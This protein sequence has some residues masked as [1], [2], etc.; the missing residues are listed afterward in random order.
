MLIPYK[1]ICNRYNIKPTGVLHIGAHWAEEAQDYY[2]NGVQRTVWV[3]ADPGCISH[4][5]NVLEPYPNHIIFNDCIS[6][7]DNQEV[8]LNISNNQGQSSSLLELAH[9]KIA[10][11]EVHYIDTIKLRTKRVDTLFKQ[12]KLNISDYQFVNID[13][14]GNELKA[15]KGMGELLSQVS[16]LY[17]EINELYLYTDCALVSEIDEYVAQFGFKGVETA[18][19]GNTGWGDKLYIK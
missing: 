15:L 2:N 7:R 13:I 9:H 1:D 12:N 4:A 6:D 14:Q 5:I 17:L 18:M 16:Y 19:C 11:P 10:H 8:V 3:E